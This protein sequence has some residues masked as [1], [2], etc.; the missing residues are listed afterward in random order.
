MIKYRILSEQK[1]IVLCNWGTTSAEEILKESQDLRNNPDYSQ[2]YDTIVD[3]IHFEPSFTRNEIYKLAELRADS[4][5][6]IGKIAIIAPNDLTFGV[7]RMHELIAEVEYS[8]S[9]HVFRD[10]SSALKWLDREGLDIESIFEEIRG[11]LPLAD[12]RPNDP[13]HS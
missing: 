6:S 11:K 1:L 13:H 5:Q 12:N 7:A 9:I 2:S 3:N 8:F 4:S 10:T